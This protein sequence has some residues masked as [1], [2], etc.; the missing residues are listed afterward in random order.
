MKQEMQKFLLPISMLVAVVSSVAHFLTPF[1]EKFL[2]AAA[3][4]TSS[5]DSSSN[6]DSNSSDTALRA[7][8]MPADFQHPLTIT[9]KPTIGERKLLSFHSNGRNIRSLLDE[10]SL[11][12][13]VVVHA[14][15]VNLDRVVMVNLVDATL[16]D[17]LRQLLRGYDI[18]VLYESEEDDDPQIAS[19]AIYPR[20]TGAERTSATQ[21]TGAELGHDDDTQVLITSERIAQYLSDPDELR[22][23]RALEIAI[24]NGVRVEPSLLSQLVRGD[25]SALVRFSALSA[26]GMLSTVDL[27]GTESV[28]VAAL[29]DSDEATRAHAQI[30]LNSIRDRMR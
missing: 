23:A 26:I 8:M 11:T 9:L 27:L 15:E 16:E 22:R 5:S 2:T 12:T 10:L 20:G 30:I 14:N 17:V 21:T 18:S 28:V 7:H 29:S 6:K 25:T 19:V 24:N 4:P 3:A 1:N 13:G